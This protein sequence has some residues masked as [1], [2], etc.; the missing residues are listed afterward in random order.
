MLVL[1]ESW[2]PFDR[3]ESL[4]KGTRSSGFDGQPRHLFTDMVILFR[5]WLHAPLCGKR[6]I[7]L[8]WCVLI[9]RY[10]SISLLLCRT[11]SCD[12][13][14]SL[15]THL[16]PARPL[17]LPCL[18]LSIN[19]EEHPRIWLPHINRCT[20]TQTHSQ[21]QT[22]LQSACVNKVLPTHRPICLIPFALS[23]CLNW[24]I[25]LHYKHALCNQ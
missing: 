6:K 1:F 4:W 9:W 15:Q 3:L 12:S 25:Y 14:R 5:G 23:L 18:K 2:L 21:T 20:T 7:T 16:Q 11:F 13:G 8:W 19:T 17:H 22:L 24:C 10:E